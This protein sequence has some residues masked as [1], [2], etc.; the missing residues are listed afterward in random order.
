[1]STYDFGF[2]GAGN[3]ATALC[4]ALI[5]SKQGLALVPAALLCFAGITKSAQLPFSGW[6]LGAMVAPTPVSALLHSSTMVK[7]GVYLVLRMAPVAQHEVGVREADRL[8]DALQFLVGVL[9]I[10]ADRH[11]AGDAPRTLHAEA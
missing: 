6:L 5:A 11:A 1:M 3:M 2:I 9:E 8:P 10:A 7:A 4:R